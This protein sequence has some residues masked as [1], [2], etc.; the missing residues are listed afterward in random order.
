MDANANEIASDPM[1]RRLP[2]RL[3]GDDRRVIVRPFVLS[4]GRVR[5]LF[6]RVDQMGENAVGRLL[7]EVEAG[8]AD[9]HARLHESFNEHYR[10]GAELIGWAPRWSNARRALAGAYLTME[11]AVDSAALFNPSIV[12]HPDQSNVARGDVRFLMSLRA[13]GEGHVS[14]IVFRTGVIT[15]DLRV[16]VDPPPAR[17]H[18]SRVA[19]DRCYEQALFRR[20]LGE[21]GLDAVIVQRVLQGVPERFTL[22]QL[23]TAVEAARRPLE[24]IQNAGETM[25]TMLFLAQSNYHVDL[26][27]DAPIS[28]LVIFP[29]NDDESR[30]IEDLRMVRFVE[31]DGAASYYGTYAAYNGFRTLPMLMYSTDFRRI[32]IHSLNGSAVLNK[33]MA[34][35][36]RRIGGRFVMCS[37]IDGENLF[38]SYS[39]SI[40]FWE[41]AQRLVTPK[42]PWELMQIGNCGSPIETPQGWLLLTHGVGPVRS[43]AIGAVLLDLHDPLRVIGHLREP[44]IAPLPHEREGYVPN[45]VYTCGAMAHGDALLIPYAQADKSTGISVVNLRRLID[46]LIDEGS[47]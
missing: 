2:I 42:Y 36:P 22:D 9:R 40:H 35:F 15:G 7:A 37:R 43:Y 39:D 30:G 24:G 20:T 5:T 14:S 18:R 6:E 3:T 11:Y 45:V 31:A 46:R 10:L 26:A 21:V 19:P 25:R 29:M 1:V 33:G 47:G 13:T 23:S 12:P 4:N 32:E 44:L 38:I 28:E 41:R 27:P 16:I 34:L 17:L 8:Y